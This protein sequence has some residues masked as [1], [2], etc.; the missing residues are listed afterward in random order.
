MAPVMSA[1][2]PG[3]SLDIT[4]MIICFLILF[5][6]GCSWVGFWQRQQFLPMLGEN[7]HYCTDYKNQQAGK[8]HFTGYDRL[9]CHLCREFMSIFGLFLVYFSLFMIL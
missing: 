8:S 2:I 1:I 7:R 5:T 9:F 4:E 3:L 6:P